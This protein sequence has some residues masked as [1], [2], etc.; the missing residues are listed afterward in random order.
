MLHRGGTDQLR[1]SF[2][3]VIKNLLRDGAEFGFLGAVDH[4]R[5]IFSFV[6]NRLAR[7]FRVGVVGV[8]ISVLVPGFFFDQCA[9]LL[10]G[11]VFQVGRD[12]DDV[13]TVDF[14]KFLFFRQSR[15]GH[16]ADLVVHTVVVLQGDGSVGDVF[17]LHLDA[18]LGF[19][20][21][22]QAVG[23]AASGHQT[24]GEGVDDDD[25]SGL[26][27]IVFVA[28]ENEFRLQSLFDIAHHAFLF[29]GDLFRAGGVTE[30]HTKH[31]FD[32]IQPVIIQVDVAV[33][34]TDFI[35]IRAQLFDDPGDPVVFFHIIR[36][37]PGDDQRGP[38]FINED[39]VDFI[40]H[41][42]GMSALYPF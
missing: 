28:F 39:V 40:D 26:D 42:I 29:D 9:A 31:F 20:G 38:G 34:F 15:S 19:N 18:F 36:C 4:I 23:P 33:L 27:E 11:G 5:V 41:G 2:D 10:P 30:H 21:L 7:V 17:R 32:M 37:R 35:F 3:I 1:A 13:Q 8:F 12:R 24:A 22:M 14:V 16:T 25:L 6:V